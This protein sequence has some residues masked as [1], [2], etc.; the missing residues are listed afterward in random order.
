[1]MQ[2]R[3]CGTELPLEA[4]Y[5]PI[6]GMA[7]PYNASDIDS[8]PISSTTLTST[9][10][11]QQQ[12]TAVVLESPFYEVSQKPPDQLTPHTVPPRRQ[13][14]RTGLLIGTIALVLVLVG[15]GTLVLLTLRANTQRAQNNNLQ[16]PY[17]PYNGT[18]VF[19][20]P[21][22]ENNNG[23]YSFPNAGNCKFLGGAYHVTAS[24]ALH[25]YPC[26]V[27]GS[28][29]DFAYQVQ[30]TIV[31]GDAGGMVFRFDAAN[32]QDFYYLSID[33]T[34]HY[35]L[36][37][38]STGHLR[39]L[40]SGLCLSFHTGLNQANLIA[41]VALGKEIDLYVNMQHCFSIRDNSYSQG[42][43]G[44]LA[45]DQGN[46]TEVVYSNA[47]VWIPSLLTDAQIDATTTAQ[48]DATAT[49]SAATVATATTTSQNPYPPYHGTLALSDSLSKNSVHSKWD[50]TV[51]AAG[52]ACKFTEGAYHVNELVADHFTDC[53]ASGSD[54][55]D[56]AYQVQMTIVKGDRGGFVFRVDS[57]LDEDFYYFNINMVGGYALDIYS[58]KGYLK[59]LSSGFSSAFHRGFNQMNL[60]AVVAQG[61]KIDLYVNLQHIVSVSDGTYSHGQ[62]GV[63]AE[64]DFNPAEV[65]YS[66]AK[67][68]Q[69]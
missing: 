65:V 35:A 8:P 68:W 20:N 67:V 62:I 30:M 55:S 41:V 28:F 34:G 38:H 1:M 46:P 9:A 17:S 64:D 18:L 19:N 33:K 56:F 5:C 25:F 29:R 42:Q 24:L 16:N 63:V 15:S 39:M 36:A 59:T 4:K 48:I 58:T 7:V 10:D 57:T 12:K 31:R 49:T 6:C 22:S 54:F 21:L 40:M 27:S 45:D 43:I 61:S 14:N 51:N 44:V 3:T 32:K 2:C 52:Y 50:E 53:V 37:I 69:L 47:K 13:V 60:I 11:A 23:Y 66:N 26:V